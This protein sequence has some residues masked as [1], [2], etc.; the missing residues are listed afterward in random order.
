MADN[1]NNFA[2]AFARL[3]A[4]SSDAGF[5]KFFGIQT[6]HDVRKELRMRYPKHHWPE[7][8]WTAEA[9]ERH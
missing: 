2:F 6:Y 3:Q 5:E 7:D 9:V 4:R 1:K 8:P